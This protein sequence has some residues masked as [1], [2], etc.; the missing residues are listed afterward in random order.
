[1]NEAAFWALIDQSLIC[2]QQGRYQID[3]LE[4]LLMQL[5]PGEVAD[6]RRHTDRLVQRA[7]RGELWAAG[8][9]LNGGHGSDDGFLYFR[10]WL[11]SCGKAVYYRALESPDSLAEVDVELDDESGAPDAEFEDFL[12]L[13][14][15]VYEKITGGKDLY[16]VLDD[17]S[18]MPEPVPEWGDGDYES[19]AWL[20]GHLPKLWHLYGAFW[21][22]FQSALGGLRV[23]GI[24]EWFDFPGVGVMKVGDAIYHQTFGRGVIQGIVVHSQTVAEA[25]IVFDAATDGGEHRHAKMLIDGSEPFSRVPFDAG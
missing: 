6:F 18:D 24:S 4:G 17:Q 16:D 1:M 7:E 9:L 23:K 8:T 2:M 14:V 19:Q 20:Q 22:R 13:P 12:Y 3:C 11:V 5:Q 25:Y 21:L 10:A 15:D